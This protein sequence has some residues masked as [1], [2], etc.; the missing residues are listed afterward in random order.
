[1]IKKYSALKNVIQAVTEEIKTVLDDNK[2]WQLLESSSAKSGIFDGGCLIFAQA[3]QIVYRGQIV[4]IVRKN[5]I[6]EHYGLKASFG[7]LDGYGCHSSAQ[8]WLQNYTR[9]EDLPKAEYSVLSGI[10]KESGILS[11]IETSLKIANLWN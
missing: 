6:T 7:Y 10:D 9:E 3:L 11:D 1:M 5:G 4:R 8:E 2:V